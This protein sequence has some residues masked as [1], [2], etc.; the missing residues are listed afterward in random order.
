MNY[1]GSPDHATTL[2]VAH[3]KET[4]VLLY[5]ISKTNVYIVYNCNYL[6]NEKARKA[7]GEKYLKSKNLAIIIA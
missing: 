2:S 3:C 4:L 6:D 1:P 7:C 5:N